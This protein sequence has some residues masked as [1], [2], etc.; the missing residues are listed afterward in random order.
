[1][2]NRYLNRRTLDW[3]KTTCCYLMDSI[4][5]STY[6]LLLDILIKTFLK[7]NDQL[8]LLKKALL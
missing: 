7:E 1:M 8:C 5:T 6:K 4:K 2:S 3:R